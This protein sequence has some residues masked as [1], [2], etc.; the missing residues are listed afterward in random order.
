MAEPAHAA[1][2]HTAAPAAEAVIKPDGAGTL[3]SRWH[4]AQ[5]AMPSSPDPSSISIRVT[6]PKASLDNNQAATS[7]EAAEGILLG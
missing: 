7:K 2:P 3:R 5:G 1:P 6:R 4:Q